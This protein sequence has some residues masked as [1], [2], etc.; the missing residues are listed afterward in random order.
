MRVILLGAPGAGKGTQARFITEKFG[1][2][3][4][5]TGDMLREAIRNGTAEGRAADSYVHKGALVPDFFEVFPNRVVIRCGKC[6]KEFVRNLVHGVEEPVFVCPEAHCKTR[7][8]VPVYY[9]K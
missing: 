7:N 3:Q 8:W 2:P 9:D 1:I 4:I 6:R 5:S